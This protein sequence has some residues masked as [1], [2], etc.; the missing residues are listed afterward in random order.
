MVEIPSTA[1]GVTDHKGPP[2]L[3]T[4]KNSAARFVYGTV[5]GT[6]SVTSGDLVFVDDFDAF[7]PRDQVP[8]CVTELDTIVGV[9]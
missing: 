9:E 2:D 6:S 5:G 4:T 7:V 8:E 1:Y 3:I